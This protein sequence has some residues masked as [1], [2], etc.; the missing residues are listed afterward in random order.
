MRGSRGVGTRVGDRCSQD[1]NSRTSVARQGSSGVAIQGE[2][3]EKE[4]PFLNV[5]HCS[6]CVF[7]GI[8]FL[9]GVI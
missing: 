1:G 7:G 2:S 8:F 5:D 4:N 9:I 3:N 6:A